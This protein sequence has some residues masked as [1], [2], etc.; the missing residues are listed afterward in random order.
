MLVIQTETALTIMTRTVTVLPSGL[1]GVFGPRHS[2]Q[3]LTAPVERFCSAV[4]MFVIPTSTPRMSRTPS[5]I[6]RTILLPGTVVHELSHAAAVILT[7]GVQVT[8]FD[9]TSHVTHRGRYTVLRAFF[10][11]YAPLLLHTGCALLATVALV[12][13]PVQTTTDLVTAGGLAYAVVALGMTALPSWL[14]AVFPLSL[15]KQRLR[16]VRGLLLFP[17]ILVW[18][19]LAL[20]GLVLSFLGKQS[21]LLQLMFGAVYTGLIVA[22]GHSLAT[23]E[24]TGLSLAML[25]SRSR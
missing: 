25:A 24:V 20:P 15:C 11:S 17:L 19:A 16:S 9:A 8:G 22:G 6:V 10:I 7:P 14:D 13:H 1:G 4:A 2:G 23:T 21:S 5:S 12:D 18:T 3:R